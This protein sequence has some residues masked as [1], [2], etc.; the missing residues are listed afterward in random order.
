M[1]YI[2][3]LKCAS[4]SHRFEASFADDLLLLLFFFAYSGTKGTFFVL[5]FLN[6]L[7]PCS[8]AASAAGHSLLRTFFLI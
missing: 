8:A 3:V 4:F 7:S 1:F 6:L 5:S 2:C